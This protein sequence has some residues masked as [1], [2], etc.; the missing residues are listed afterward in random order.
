MKLKVF[1]LFI[2]HKSYKTITDSG[3][4]NQQRQSVEEGEDD[5]REKKEEG[6]GGTAEF[7]STVSKYL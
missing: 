4:E 7:L 2:K 3:N 5:K 6:W 1:L